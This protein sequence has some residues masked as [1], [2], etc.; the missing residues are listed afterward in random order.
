MTHQY[1]PGNYTVLLFTMHNR[2]RGRLQARNYQ[3]GVNAA[4]RWAR[5]TGGSAV[6]MK[7]LFNTTLGRGAYPAKWQ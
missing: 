4:Q 2:K 1:D 7:C 6:L 5:R 3:R